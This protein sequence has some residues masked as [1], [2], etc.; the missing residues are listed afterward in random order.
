MIIPGLSGSFLLLVVGL[1]R[2]VIKAVS[3]LNVALLIP[4]VLGAALGILLGA[5]LVRFLLLKAPKET[6]C[7][8]LG[9]IIGSIAVLYPGSLGSDLTMIFSILSA[10]LGCAVSFFFGRKEA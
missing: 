5:A 10:F 4:V 7:A 2:T 1:Y 9:L 3:D 6:Y 8:A